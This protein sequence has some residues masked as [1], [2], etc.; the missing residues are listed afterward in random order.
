MDITKLNYYDVDRCSS[1]SLSFYVAFQYNGFFTSLQTEQIADLKKWQGAGKEITIFIYIFIYRTLYVNGWK[2]SDVRGVMQTAESPWCP[3]ERPWPRGEE[4]LSC[5]P[6]L[7]FPRSPASLFPFSHVRW[8]AWY[9]YGKVRSPT[10]VGLD[11][12]RDT[13]NIL[14]GNFSQI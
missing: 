4:I 3:W 9:V 14:F 5:R 6:R 1:A 2:F 11:P 7:H 12:A 8:T 10:Y 13:L